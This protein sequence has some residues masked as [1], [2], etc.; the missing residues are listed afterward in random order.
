MT[1]PPNQVKLI[2]TM[3]P[4]LE[5]QAIHHKGRDWVVPLA[6][7]AQ[8]ID[9]WAEGFDHKQP[10]P[11]GGNMPMRIEEE[12]FLCESLYRELQFRSRP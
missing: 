2:L 11:V 9:Q 8:A 10:L 5:R 6:S 12:A 3:L 7:W 4:D 1:R